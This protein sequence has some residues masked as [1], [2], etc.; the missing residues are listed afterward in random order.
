MDRAYRNPALLLRPSYCNQLQLNIAAPL[1]SKYSITRLAIHTLL[2]FS[3]Y[4]NI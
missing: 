2:D 1:P 3:N 4:S